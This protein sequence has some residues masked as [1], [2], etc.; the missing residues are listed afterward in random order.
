MTILV[1]DD[2]SAVLAVVERFLTRRGHTVLAA[3]DPDD[4]RFVIAEHG[5]PPDVLLVDIVLA[6]RSGIDYARSM[7]TEHRELKT[8]L[9]TGWSHRAPAGLRSGIGPVLHKPFT[10]QQLYD[11]I[12]TEVAGGGQDK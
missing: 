9:M 1:V 8:V 6:D 2:D 4:A 10:A 5:R 11:A 7:R 3:S 12:E